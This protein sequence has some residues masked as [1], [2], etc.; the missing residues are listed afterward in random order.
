MQHCARDEA[1]PRGTALSQAG[2]AAAKSRS[3]VV[4]LL[5]RHWPGSTG[6]QAGNRTIPK[7]QHA[8]DKP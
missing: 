4:T 3:R 8:A 6:S 2:A 5:L 1:T 7:R